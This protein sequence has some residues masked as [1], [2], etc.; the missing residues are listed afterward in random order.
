MKAVSRVIKE[1]V[2]PCL[3]PELHPEPYFVDFLRDPLEPT[4]GEDDNTCFDA[5]KVY[6]L[7]RTL[8]LDRHIIFVLLMDKTVTK[9]KAN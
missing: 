4:G 9:I 7:V 2:D 3:V 1:H 5:P 6:E 8:Y